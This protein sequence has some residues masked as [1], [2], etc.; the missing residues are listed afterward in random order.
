MKVNLAKWCAVFGVAAMMSSPVFAGGVRYEDGDKYL[1]LGGRVQVQYRNIDV[2]EGGSIDKLFFRRLRPYIEGSAHKDWKAKWQFDLG[3]GHLKLKDAYFKYSGYDWGNV[4]VGNAYV[5]FSREATT[6]SK[7]QQLV[8]RTFVGDHNY[9][10][11]DRQLGVHLDG[12]LSEAFSWS[13]SL[14]SMAHDPNNRKLDFESP[15]DIDNGV[16]FQEGYGAAGR[17]AFHPMGMVKK[18]Q[19]D[20]GTESFVFEFA[21]GGFAWE[22]DKDNLLGLQRD[23]DGASVFGGEAAD[24]IT[25]LEVSLAV[26][27][28]GL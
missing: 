24:T 20:F 22:N 7:Y 11:P 17:V 27:G 21:V 14:A 23:A 8:E 19:G 2:D 16:D 3:G 12:D 15:A 1:K 28:A 18:S 9:G 10:S 4:T 13:S 6:S 5:Q 25:G 26:R